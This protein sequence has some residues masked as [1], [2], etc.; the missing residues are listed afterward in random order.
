VTDLWTLPLAEGRKTG[1]CEDYA[2]EKIRT[3]AAQGVPRSALNIALAVT[4]WGESHA[5]LVVSTRSGD[6]VLD[7]L[8]PSVIRWDAV[9]YR[10]RQRQVGGEAFRWA[11]VKQGARIGG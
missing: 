4:G 1:D 11:M 5:V 8:T 9:P 2:L 3:L 10:W 6:F 7:N